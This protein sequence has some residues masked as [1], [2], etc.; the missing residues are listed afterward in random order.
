MK[1]FVYTG[2][3]VIR[4]HVVDAENEEQARKLVMAGKVKPDSEEAKKIDI[5][6]S[7]PLA[8]QTLPAGNV[9]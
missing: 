5:R 2:H 8:D 1:Y 7:Y 6:F 4:Q 9:E 3:T